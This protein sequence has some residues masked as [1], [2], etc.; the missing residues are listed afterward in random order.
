[1]NGLDGLD[2][3]LE[4]APDLT[5]HQNLPWES[6]PNLMR[7]DATVEGLDKGQAQVMLYE[8]ALI[9]RLEQWLVDHESLVHGPVHS[10]IGQEAVAIGAIAA[11][12]PGDQIA[13]TSAASRQECL[14]RVPSSEAASPWPPEPRLALLTGGPAV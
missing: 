13:C 5:A 8:L 7:V 12:K 3:M 10:S 11:L 1:M 9:R 14:E 6:Y 2:S 4:G